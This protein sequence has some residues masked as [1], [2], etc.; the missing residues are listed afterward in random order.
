LY[1]ACRGGVGLL[2]GAFVDVLDGEATP[3]HLNKHLPE[4]SGREVVEERVEN[5][6]QVEEGVGHELE[7][8]VAPEVGKSPVGFGNSGLHEAMN[9][10]GKPANHQR[11]N[12]ET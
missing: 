12:D 10:V 5:R 6:A 7:G 3:Q 11:S 1:G 8:C 9:L 4:L 2:H